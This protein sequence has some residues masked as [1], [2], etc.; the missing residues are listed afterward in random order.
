MGSTTTRSK[1]SR[2]RLS[3]RAI[4]RAVALYLEGLT[5]HEI[6]KRLRVSRGAVAHRLRRATPEQ[7]AAMVEVSRAR[8]AG[9]MREVVEERRRAAAALLEDRGRAT[10]PEVAKAVGI[11]RWA[12]VR[13]LRRLGAIVVEDRGAISDAS[14]WALPDEVAT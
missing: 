8:A 12:A 9:P 10:A 7:R 11:T 2:D 14:L 6:A 3:R 13:L 4:D 5:Q 1:A